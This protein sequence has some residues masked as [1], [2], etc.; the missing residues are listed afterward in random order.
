MRALLIVIS[1]SFAAVIHA[2]PFLYYPADADHLF[3]W[4]DAASDQTI[5]PA[6]VN[7]HWQN[8]AALRD[9]AWKTA[10]KAEND[11]QIGHALDLLAKGD[12][13]PGA[14]LRGPDVHALF[15]SLGND[16][17]LF[18]G[19]SAQKSFSVML[20]RDQKGEWSKKGNIPITPWLGASSDPEAW[21]IMLEPVPSDWPGFWNGVGTSAASAAGYRAVVLPGKRWLLIESMP[22]TIQPAST[23]GK[24]E[25]VPVTNNPQPPQPKW[26]EPWIWYVAAFAGGLLLG[27]VIGWLLRGRT[28]LMNE[29]RAVSDDD[30]TRFTEALRPHIKEALQAAPEEGVPPQDNIRAKLQALAEVCNETAKTSQTFSDLRWNSQNVDGLLDGMPERLRKAA[31][32]AKQTEDALTTVTAKKKELEQRVS[33]A[34]QKS[35]EAQKTLGRVPIL[36][37][38]KKELEGK[39]TKANEEKTAAI[40]AETEKSRSQLNALKSAHQ[41]ELENTARDLTTI[42]E[43]FASLAL[44]SASF[45]E[46][47]KNHYADRRD[48][49]AA[50]MLG[51]LANHSLHQLGLGIARDRGEQRQYML[52]NLQKIAQSLP[53]LD[54]YRRAQQEIDRNFLPPTRPSDAIVKQAADRAEAP[55]FQFALRYLRETAR[56]DLAPYYFYVDDKGS[57]YR[58]A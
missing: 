19:I 35:A 17:L 13:V 24:S 21:K 16:R 11:E 36:E 7:G 45:Q 3:L 37:A 54:G 34:E 28:K 55:L 57:P 29:R 33:D 5:A 56:V 52:L 49:A 50:A 40:A 6:R 31:S 12:T 43:S 51:F 44:V 20:E 41:A 53:E 46:G 4:R 58:A 15:T 42:R 10:L 38:Q 23:P 9:P 32:T 2:Q 39:L 1:L 14:T 48:G 27:F 47:Q 26:W 18:T 30:I 22:M 25:K 8:G